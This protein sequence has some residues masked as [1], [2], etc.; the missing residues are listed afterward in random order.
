MVWLDPAYVSESFNLGNVSGNTA[1]ANA[2]AA[3][4]AYVEEVRPDFITGDTEEL[5]APTASVKFG[6]AMLAARLYER[7]GALLGVAPSAGY[8]EAATIVRSDPDVE[9][10]LGIG[11]AR[12]FGFG[13][14]PLDDEE[15]EEVT[16]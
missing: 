10:L 14:A 4:A 5:Y 3:A 2:T 15:T 13:S 8:E 11:R 1:L 12:P 6:A 7:R 16:A 9:R